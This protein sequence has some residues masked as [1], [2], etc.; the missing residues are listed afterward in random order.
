MTKRFYEEYVQ[1]K[2]C[3]LLSLG[4]SF[5]GGCGTSNV[6]DAEPSDT[7]VKPS[8][9]PTEQT[10]LDPPML[11]ACLKA[12]KT[13]IYQPEALA[14]GAAPGV[15][16]FTFEQ[17][18]KNCGLVTR[19]YLVHV[20]ASLPS[21][22]EAPVVIGLPGQGANAESLRE[23]QAR[24]QFDKL[25]VS[26]GFV[27]VYGN[28]LPTPYN[29]E[30]LANSG[31]F[32]SEYSDLSKEVDELEYLRLII[33]D[34]KSR[35]LI[36]GDNRVFL[37]GHSNGGGLAL[38]ATQHHPERYAG[39]AAFM[40]YVGYAPEAPKDLRSTQL[41]RIMFVVSS[42]DPAFPEDYAT[43]VQLPLANGYGRALGID[44]AALASPTRTAIFDSVQE[45]ADY[46]GSNPTVTTTR[47]STV[48]QLDSS[49][50]Y[51]KLR[52]LHMDHAGHFWPT[53]QYN[54]QSSAQE[55]YGLRNQD[56][57]GAVEAWRFFAE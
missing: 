41:G 3:G 55:R 44:E 10:R 53:P 22:T 24:G 50:S 1:N 8:D 26:D 52:V 39:V 21:A 25:A 29:F 45:G 5:L 28:G 16:V 56:I 33:E 30:G 38:S 7:L 32:R 36:R 40:P 31:E 37:V 6:P 15:Q 46:T 27:M 42:T 11:L 12:P 17:E 4:L 47:Q 57:D 18:T 49:S 2:L 9:T 20:P 14:P 54:D 51:G 13:A 19:R 34:M 23:F 48:V 35:S 43:S